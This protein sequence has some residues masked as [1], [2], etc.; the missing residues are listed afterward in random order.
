MNGVAQ[1]TLKIVCYISH[2]GVNKF[3]SHQLVTTIGLIALVLGLGIIFVGYKFAGG[4][5]NRK[6]IIFSIIASLLVG[7]LTFPMLIKIACD[8]HAQNNCLTLAIIVILEMI[9]VAFVAVHSY[10]MTTV[11]AEEA[12]ARTSD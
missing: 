4:V 5:H 6:A 9:F 10:E 12:H 1:D 3:L 7:F 2:E 11:T 8:I